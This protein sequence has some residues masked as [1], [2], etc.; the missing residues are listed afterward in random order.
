M[1]F[2]TT[3]V[4]NFFD[5]PNV[6]RELAYSLERAPDKEGKWPGSRTEPLHIVAPDYHNFF[7]SKLFSLF[8]DFKCQKVGWD[9]VTYFQFLEPYSQ[10]ELVNVGWVHKDE[11]AT[12]AGVVYLNENAQL[13]AGTSLFTPKKLGGVPIHTTE[14]HNFYKFE[15]NTTEDEYV[16]KLQENNNL[17][18]E[19]MTIGN[20][21]NRM[22]CYDAANYHRANGFTSGANEPRLTQVFFVRK[23]ISNWFPIPSMRAV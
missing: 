18:T 17:F 6:V 21:Y 2:P 22:I 15:S 5:N 16:K 3:C 10:N 7:S 14:K 23:V 13:G 4:D 12:F 11:E 20:V 8:Y 1:L 9:V 19:T